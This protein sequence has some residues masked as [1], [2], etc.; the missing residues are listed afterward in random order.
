MRSNCVTDLDAD[1]PTAGLV[2]IILMSFH[3]DA[4]IRREAE[5]SIRPHLQ[6][7]HLREGKCGDWTACCR[8]HRCHFW[9]FG[10]GSFRIGGGCWVVGGGCWVVQPGVEQRRHR[11]RPGGRH[12]GADGE[13]GMCRRRSI[14]HRRDQGRRQHRPA[15]QYDPL[16][17]TGGRHSRVLLKSNP[18]TEEKIWHVYRV[19]AG[20]RAKRRVCGRAGRHALGKDG[21]IHGRGQPCHWAMSGARSQQRCGWGQEVPGRAATARNAAGACTCRGTMYDLLYIRRIHPSIAIAIWFY[22]SQLFI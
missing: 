3:Y 20:W 22:L 5:R 19:Q 9:I 1:R 18:G 15:N 12:R 6:A 10:F 16:Q 14:R 8:F 21:G 2:S 4:N 11:W 13:V 17:S 7:A